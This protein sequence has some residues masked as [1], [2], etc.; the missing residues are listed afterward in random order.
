MT[1]NLLHCL[2]LLTLEDYCPR[3]DQEVQKLYELPPY[4]Q[5]TE[6]CKPLFALLTQKLGQEI[7]DVIDVG[8]VYDYYKIQVKTSKDIRNA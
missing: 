4:K 8:H 2:Q 6:R 7:V 3:I 1:V 5:M